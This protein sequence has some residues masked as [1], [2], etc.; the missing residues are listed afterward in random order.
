MIK[1]YVVFYR[2]KGTSASVFKTKIIEAEDV[3]MA[4]YKVREQ[5]FF[6]RGIIPYKNK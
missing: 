4:G 2:P 6:V 5:G 3:R 1:K